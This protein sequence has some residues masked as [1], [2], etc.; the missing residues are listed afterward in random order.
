[1]CLMNLILFG[2]AEIR[3]TLD[4]DDPR[5]VH[6]LKVLKRRR[7]EEFDAGIINGPKGKGRL[8]KIEEN[9]LILEFDLSEQP[10]ELYPVTLITGLT[11]PQIARRILREATILGINC[12]EFIAT[13]KGE[14]SYARSRLWANREYERHLIVGAQQAFTTRL[15]TVRLFGS[16]RECLS[17][18]TAHEERIACDKIA[19][20]KIALDNYE[21]TTPLREIAPTTTACVL[22]AVGPERG[23]SKDERALLRA[24]GFTLASL[25]NRVLGTETACVAGISLVLANQGYM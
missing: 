22:L 15:P 3:H 5:A 1:M 9:R 19:C 7:G 24:E 11:R 13:D 16:L 25:G 4:L 21:A 2:E 12:M 14:K 23:W 10:V 20:D 6:I 8:L 18:H 17:H